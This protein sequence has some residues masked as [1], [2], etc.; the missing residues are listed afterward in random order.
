M[1]ERL[2]SV[3]IYLAAYLLPL[4]YCILLLK[5]GAEGD[6]GGVALMVFFSMIPVANIIVATVLTIGNLFIMI[7]H[8]FTILVEFV[9]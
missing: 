1:N 6:S 5:Y 3:L 9:K 4:I 2:E 8:L 7:L